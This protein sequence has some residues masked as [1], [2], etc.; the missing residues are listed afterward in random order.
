[1][2]RSSSLLAVD[3]GTLVSV[4]AIMMMFLQTIVFLHIETW[5]IHRM[6]YNADDVAPTDAPASLSA[7]R[8]AAPDRSGSKGKTLYFFDFVFLIS[9]TFKPIT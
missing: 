7:R 4:M 6:S 3:V 2:D 1:M 8:R 5:N 9:T